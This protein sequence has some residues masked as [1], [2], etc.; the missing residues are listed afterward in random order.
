MQIAQ[1][2]KEILEKH[3]LYNYLIRTTLQLLMK[4]LQTHLEVIRN[5]RSR[6]KGNLTSVSVKTQNLIIPLTPTREENH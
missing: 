4:Y 6:E 3:R 2:H 1:V 5:P